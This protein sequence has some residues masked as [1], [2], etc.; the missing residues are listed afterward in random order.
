MARRTICSS[1][2]TSNEIISIKALQS[3]IK[4]SRA[5]VIKIYEA[6]GTGCLMERTKTEKIS[7]SG[8]TVST[9]SNNLNEAICYSQELSKKIYAIFT[10]RSCPDRVLTVG[11]GVHFYGFT[12][13]CVH[14]GV[15]SVPYLLHMLENKNFK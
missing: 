6:G 14:N 8:I 10:V 11:V 15:L 5:K 13:D 12:S 9:F 1:S 3:I 2:E 4:S 7:Y